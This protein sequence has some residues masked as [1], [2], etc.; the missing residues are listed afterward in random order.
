LTL[1]APPKL[2]RALKTAP[3]FLDY[4]AERRLFRNERTRRMLDA[5]GIEL[6][7]PSKYLPRVIDYY[8]QRRPARRHGA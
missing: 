3:I 6:P 4:L 2:R 1:V 5:D 7:A 8:L